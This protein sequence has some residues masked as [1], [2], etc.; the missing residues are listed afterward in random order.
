MT[1]HEKDRI[2]RAAAGDEAAFAE[3]VT[4]YQT[5]VYNMA[6]S[7]LR[8][9]EDALD[10]SQEIFL[11]VYRSLPR[12]RFESAF[13]TWLYRLTKNAVLDHLRAQKR[14]PK[15][16]LEALEEQ[17]VT[18]RDE[19]ECADPFT[20]LLTAERRR[21]LYDAI[22]ELSEDHREVI[23]LTVFCGES[24][25]RVAEILSAEVGTVKSRVF[26]AK[27]ELRKLLEKRNFF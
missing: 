20:A 25:E 21:M 18:V 14:K 4:A 8:N 16:A 24:Y 27:K 10:V 3:L 13:S 2:R 19:S 26:R 6:L 22:E 9:R 15:A 11:K 1:E 5:M 17:G 12:Y 7:L 23:R